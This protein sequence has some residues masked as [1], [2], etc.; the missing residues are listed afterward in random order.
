MPEPGRWVLCIHNGGGAQR[1]AEGRHTLC[2]E[3][4]E[5]IEDDKGRRTPR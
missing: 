2:T 1:C 3:R 5:W 4:A